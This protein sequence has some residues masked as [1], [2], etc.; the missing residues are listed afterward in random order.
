M[1]RNTLNYRVKAVIKRTGL[2]IRSFDMAVTFKI[3]H[4][5]YLNK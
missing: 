1:H 2:D 3:L 4:I 5:L